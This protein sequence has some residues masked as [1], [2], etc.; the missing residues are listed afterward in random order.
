MQI[1][2]LV[3]HTTPTFQTETACRLKA[4]PYCHEI[5]SHLGGVGTVCSPI[6]A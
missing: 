6:A 4:I 2:N 5:S 3:I 1:V